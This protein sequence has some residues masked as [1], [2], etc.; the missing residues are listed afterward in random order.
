MKFSFKVFISTIMVIAIVSSIGSYILIASS[1]ESDIQRETK[2]GLDEYQLTRFAFESSMLSAQMQY[3]TVTEDILES[4]VK[5]TAAMA[6]GQK[7]AVY[8][9]AGKRLAS[10]PEKFF[11][12]L[13]LTSIAENEQHYQI[14]DASGA[15][16]L[17]IAGSLINNGQKLYL[18][19]SHDMEEIF[20]KREDLIR[21]FIIL[22]LAM[23]AVGA[24]LMWGLS[25]ALTRPIRQL[26]KSARRIANGRYHERVNVKTKDEIGELSSSFNNMASAVEQNISDLKQYA[27]QQEDFVANLSHELKTPFTSIIG[28]ADLL[29]SEELEPQDTFKAASFIFSEGKRLEALSI[30][31]MDMI[32]LQHHDFALR[33]VNI[34]QLLRHTAEVVSPLLLQSGM[35]IELI[36]EKRIV[37]AESDLL[38]TLIINLIDN[39]RKASEGGKIVLSGRTD[40]RHYKIS[41]R[42]FGK[43]IPKEEIARITEAFY[44]VDKSRARA[45]HG[46]GLGL[47][48]AERIAKIH[49]SSLTFESEINQGTLVSFYLPLTADAEKGMQEGQEA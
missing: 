10:F 2:R 7:L 20:E 16:V 23:I 18:T 30:K 15:H 13:A 44:M 41:V 40:G 38:M 3:S 6:N 27:Q 8:D 11:V 47:S 36:A 5:Q 33:P 14:S 45:Q 37:Y 43:G 42:D 26:K 9:S 21:L 4:I 19:V 24:L 22:D 31:L 32:V 49:G 48:I 35:K 34:K 46:A 25:L 39:S 12:S 1:F 17:E 29:R 28:Y